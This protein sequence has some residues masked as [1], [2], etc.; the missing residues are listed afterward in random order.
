MRRSSTFRSLSF[1]L[2]LGASFALMESRLIAS[3]WEYV[4]DFCDFWDSNYDCTC[5]TSTFF[6]WEADGTCDFT[7]H[8]DPEGLGN[9]YCN[10]AFEAC[11]RDCESG[12]F[13]DWLVNEECPDFDPCNPECYEEFWV[14]FLGDFSCDAGTVSDFS[15]GCDGFNWGEGGC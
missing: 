4:P 9:E 1:I 10:S 12:R 8:E 14:G 11:V 5:D 3:D 2:L 15:C 13:V 6:G 7:E